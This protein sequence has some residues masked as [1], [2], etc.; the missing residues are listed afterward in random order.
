MFP[1]GCAT[2]PPH[3]FVFPPL[4]TERAWVYRCLSS[5]DSSPSANP[6]PVFPGWNLTCDL[7]RQPQT[8]LPSL[9]LPP[10]RPPAMLPTHPSSLRLCSSDLLESFL[11]MVWQTLHCSL[12]LNLVSSGG[13][14]S[15][16][17]DNFIVPYYCPIQWAGT[18]WK[19]Y[20]KSSVL[21]SRIIV[22]FKTE[23]L[24]SVVLT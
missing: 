10:S 14:F 2:G 1:P 19:S 4:L 24:L 21:T 13:G 12:V 7:I 22:H 17:Y 16:P 6:A 9:T 20:R 5:I 3:T 18:L 11:P 23:C 8:P 15:T